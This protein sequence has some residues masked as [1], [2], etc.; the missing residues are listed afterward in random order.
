MSFIGDLFSSPSAPSAPNPTSVVNAQTGANAETARLNANLNRADSYSPFGSV[1]FE[2]MGGDRW[3]SEQTFSPEM[4][5]LY[6]GQMDIG[7]GISDAAQTRVDQFDNSKFSL[8]GVAD[9]QSSIDRGGLSGIPGLGDFDGARNE[10]EDASFNRVWDRLNPMFDQEYD[11]M[12]TNLANQGISMGS[13]AYDREMTNFDQRKNDAR[14]AAGYDSIGAGRDA[15]NNLF[16]NSMISRQQGESELMSDANMANAGRSQQINDML[17]QRGQPMNELAALLQGSPAVQTPTQQ[18]MAGAGAAAP[19]VIGAMNNQY[20]G[21][22][23]N[24]NA[25]VG[26]QNAA[27]G[28][29][30]NLGAASLMGR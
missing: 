25:K 27:M 23:A 9:Y 8:D 2:D 14:T 4:Q 30:F 15:Y 5:N 6:D 3:K 21:Q 19:D 20:A 28:G 12:Q 13:E 29:L 11:A 18:P 17:L 24:Y 7:Q 1:T 26:Q 22:M 10:A 16:N